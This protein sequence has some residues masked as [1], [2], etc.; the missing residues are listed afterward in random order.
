MAINQIF[1]LKNTNLM[2]WRQGDQNSGYSHTN[3]SRDMNTFAR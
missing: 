2:S 3:I 1:N